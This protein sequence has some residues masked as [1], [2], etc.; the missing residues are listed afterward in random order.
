MHM[1]PDYH[2]GCMVT[3]SDKTTK[4]WF[5]AVEKN[6][7]EKAEDMEN[8]I[9]IR[10]GFM[11]S[12][13]EST[14]FEHFCGGKTSVER[15]PSQ[16]KT[17]AWILKA[18]EVLAWKIR[19]M[20]TFRFRWGLDKSYLICCCRFMELQGP[21][22]TLKSFLMT[23]FCYILL[24]HIFIRN[25]TNLDHTRKHIYFNKNPYRKWKFPLKNSWIYS[26]K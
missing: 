1:R 9:Y 21:Q 4:N 25:K 2:C 16:K 18:C 23:K 5:L 12:R 15:Y 20:K 11:S 14:V 13:S 26:F 22:E 6:W 8:C 17:T 24:S 3:F 10:L 7:R 19:E